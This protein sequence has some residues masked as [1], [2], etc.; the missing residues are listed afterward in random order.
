MVELNEED[1]YLGHFELIGNTADTNWED[2]PVKIT[3]VEQDIIISVLI[4]F[5][6]K[7]TAYLRNIY[8]IFSIN[9]LSSI[10]SND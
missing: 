4:E 5:D 1:F 6:K 3:E 7:K 10:E 9:Q 8:K 2:V